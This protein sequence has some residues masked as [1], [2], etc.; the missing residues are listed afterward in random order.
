METMKELIATVK[1]TDRKGKE[2][3]LK[4]YENKCN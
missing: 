3:K 1:V 4:R 2:L